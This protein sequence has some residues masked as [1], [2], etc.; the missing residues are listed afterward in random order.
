[1]WA[2]LL[3]LIIQGK[4]RQQHLEEN[5]FVFYIF[6]HFFFSK[7]D[8]KIYSRKIEEKLLRDVW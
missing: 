4:F 8:L 5:K 6:I 3:F 7:I 1:M 2:Q